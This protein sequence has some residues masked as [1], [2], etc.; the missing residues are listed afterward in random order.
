MHRTKGINKKQERL[1]LKKKLYELIEEKISLE[2]YERLLI[3]V[4][5]IMKLDISVEQ[6]FEKFIKTKEKMKNTDS[7]WIE[8]SRREVTKQLFA[9][10]YGQTVKEVFDELEKER[11][12]KEKERQEKEKERQEHQLEERRRILNFH[13]IAGLS[14]DKIALSMGVDLAYVE[15]ILALGK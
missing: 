8:R 9:M 15:Q 10:D 7:K 12:E 6:E 1:E 14:A 13:T 2:K 4:N 3:F 5:E 11:Q